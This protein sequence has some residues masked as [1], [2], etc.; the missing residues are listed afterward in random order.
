MGDSGAYRVLNTTNYELWN[1]ITDKEAIYILGKKR[2]NRADKIVE[3]FLQVYE[4]PKYAYLRENARIR[5]NYLQAI[6]EVVGLPKVIS[7][8]CRIQEEPFVRVLDEVVQKAG[9]EDLFCFEGATSARNFAPFVYAEEAALR[10]TEDISACIGPMKEDLPLNLRLL[11][12]NKA[13]GT[14]P[15]PVFWYTRPTSFPPLTINATEREIMEVLSQDVT[16]T[17]FVEE[18]LVKLGRLKPGEKLEYIAR[19]WY[20]LMQNINAAYWLD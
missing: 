5:G 17:R 14:Q 10:E 7:M 3:R 16:T 15:M 8:E 6:A 2:L 4:E 11:Q 13:M 12:L 20:V 18:N 19:E 9:K 1:R